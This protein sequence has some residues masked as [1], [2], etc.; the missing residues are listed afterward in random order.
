MERSSPE[1]QGIPSAAILAFIEEA[2]E[3]LDA[4]HSLMIAR[5][6]H[7]VAE[8]WWAPYA[9]ELNHWLFSLSKGFTSTGVGIAIGEGRLSLDA[10]VISFFP[11]EAPNGPSENLKAMTVRDLLKMTHGH[12]ETRTAR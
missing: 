9:P 2:E 7:V 3:Q 1:S 10:P 12:R 11:D 4:L 6:G 8:G 5:N